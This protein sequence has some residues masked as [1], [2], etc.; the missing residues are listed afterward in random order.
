MY[1][2]MILGVIKEFG[3]H[4]NGFEKSKRSLGGVVKDFGVS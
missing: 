1:L 4:N 3:A 2:R